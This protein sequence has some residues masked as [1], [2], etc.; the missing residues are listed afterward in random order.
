MQ[1]W[2]APMS[3]LQRI[4][5]VCTNK[6]R[7]C[8]I[9]KRIRGKSMMC[10]ETNSS[11]RNEHITERNPLIKWCICI[12]APYPGGDYDASI[13]AAIKSS[14]SSSLFLTLPLL[15]L[16]LQYKCRFRWRK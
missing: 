13:V 8:H 9:S 11:K 3:D 5:M 16:L 15:L 4:L 1:L 10:S 12:S 6:R 7:L 2:E 14:C